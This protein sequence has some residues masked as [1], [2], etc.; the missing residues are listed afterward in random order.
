MRTKSYKVYKLEEVENTLC[1]KKKD[2]SY[3]KDIEL[4]VFKKGKSTQQKQ[5]IDTKTIVYNA[6]AYDISDIEE[7]MYVEI[8]SVKYNIKNISEFNHKVFLELG[9]D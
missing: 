2:L 8:N 3:F 4:F 6:L 5:G 7:G 9:E 1:E